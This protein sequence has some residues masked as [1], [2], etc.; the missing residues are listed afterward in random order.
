MM[1]RCAII[2]GTGLTVL[3]GLVAAGSAQSATPFGLPSAPLCSGKFHGT[4][5]VF[6]ARH[7]V[8]HNIPPHRVNYRANI[9]ALFDAGVDRI[10][11]VN[12]VGGISAGMR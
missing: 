11:A 10:I 2:G 6:L 3:D 12:A 1:K 7:G 8:D 5:V 4:E 9:R